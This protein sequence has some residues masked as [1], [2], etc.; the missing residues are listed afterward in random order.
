MELFIVKSFLET[1]KKNRLFTFVL[2]FNLES[3]GHI[4]GFLSGCELII[5]LRA[6]LK[7]DLLFKIIKFVLVVLLFLSEDLVFP[8][9]IRVSAKFLNPFLMSLFLPLLGR[10]ADHLDYCHFGTVVLSSADWSDS[11]EATCDTKIIH[12]WC[13]LTHQFFHGWPS[14]QNGL[15]VPMRLLSIFT[16]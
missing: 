5:N 14:E 13:D 15:E 1:P 16:S 8:L 6:Y 7:F 2:S 3:E 10:V 9:P 11:R 12:S 4:V